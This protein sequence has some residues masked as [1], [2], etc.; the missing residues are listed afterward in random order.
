MTKLRTL[1]FCALP[2]LLLAHPAS[3]VTSK[4]KM[5]TCK[6]GAQAQNLEGAK[7]QAFIKKCMAA[8]N[9]EPAARKEAKKKAAA[10]KRS[11]MKKKPTAAAP[12]P[13]EPAAEPEQKD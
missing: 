3:A 6:V 10:E 8:G 9:Y 11:A 1:G 4:D 12:P 13:D 2:L 5:E 7:A